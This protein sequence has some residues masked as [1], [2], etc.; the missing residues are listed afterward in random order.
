MLI[1]TEFGAFPIPASGVKFSVW[2]PE[3]KVV[4]LVIF[5]DG[6]TEEK[7]LPLLKDERGIF[8]GD[9]IKV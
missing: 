7:R 8:V 3:A 6:K 4:E 9:T 5:K 1:N 2:A